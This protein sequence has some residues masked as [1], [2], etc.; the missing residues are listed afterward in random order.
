MT[1]RDLEAKITQV[2]TYL[3]QASRYSKV[4]LKELRSNQ[5]IRLAVER[6]LFLVS[7]SSIDLAEAYCRTHKMGRP[8]SMHHA[9][10]LLEE[11]DIIPADLSQRLS[12]MV[13]FRNV[14]THGYSKIDYS[15]LIEVLRSGLKDIKQLIQLL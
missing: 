12:K 9:I 3:R 11:H 15:K 6:A 7:Q 10:E 14:L 1:K 4:T 13:G 8:D 5:D 2:K